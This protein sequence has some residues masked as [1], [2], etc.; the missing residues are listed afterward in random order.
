MNTSKVDDRSVLERVT[1]ENEQA[2]E[3]LSVN[4]VNLRNKLERI[5]PLEEKDGE[6]KISRAD[7]ARN[8]KLPYVETLLEQVERVRGCNRH[9][10]KTIAH[11]DTIA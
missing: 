1:I 2:L 7:V 6:V 4:L 5:S 8:G 10:E 11:L 3:V 9:L